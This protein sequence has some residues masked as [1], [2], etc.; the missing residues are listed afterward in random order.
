MFTLMFKKLKIFG[1]YFTLVL[2]VFSYLI[3]FHPVY[4]DK[5][6]TLKK[7]V[8]VQSQTLLETLSDL[9]SYPHIF[10]ENIKS[11]ELT[12]AKTAKFNIG[13]NGIFFDVQTKY[14]QN[15]DGS[16]VVEITSGDLK[17]TRVITTLQKTW[18]FDGTSDGGTIVNMDMILQISGMLSL[19]APTIPD[20]TILS[21]LGTS[22]D[23]FALYAKSK[24]QT[25]FVLKDKSQIKNDAML[26]SK[27][28][29]NDAAFAFEIQSMRKNGMVKISQS[30]KESSI[31][32]PSWVKTNAV[33]WTEGKISDK[34]FDSSI[35]YLIDSKIIKGSTSKLDKL[36]IETYC[37]KLLFLI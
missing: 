37:W 22:L 10:P 30:Q 21:N 8:N 24:P 18:G 26:W 17:G 32:I 27:G 25:Q 34:D 14:T 2:F 5:E 3:I 20:Q 35:Q 28:S 6:L 12:G 19:F 33:W 29:I 36:I 4:A 7:T 16:Y 15:S 11:V 23:K 9:Q 31:K 1:I 13:S